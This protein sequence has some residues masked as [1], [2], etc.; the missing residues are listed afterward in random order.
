VSRLPD[1]DDTG[2]Y[3]GRTSVRCDGDAEHSQLPNTSSRGRGELDTGDIPVGLR[4]L[5]LVQGRA[6][7]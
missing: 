3:K 2:G 6:I 5:R 4:G 1:C 7:G